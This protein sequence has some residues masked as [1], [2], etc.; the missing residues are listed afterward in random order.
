MCQLGA[1]LGGS[2]QTHKRRGH[3]RWTPHHPEEQEMHKRLF[4]NPDSPRNL[5]PTGAYLHFQDHGRMRTTRQTR[6]I[7]RILQPESLAS[8]T[9]QCQNLRDIYIPTVKLCL[10]FT[11]P[12]TRRLYRWFGKHM[13]PTHPPASTHAPSSQSTRVRSSHPLLSDLYAWTSDN[14]PTKSLICMGWKKE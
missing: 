14:I 9:E 4:V 13:C 7:H 8:Q 3:P 12:E 1:L 11:T 2:D 5:R 6:R 10:A